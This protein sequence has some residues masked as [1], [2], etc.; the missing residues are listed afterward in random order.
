LGARSC[1]DPRAGNSATSWLP[2][3]EHDAVF[4]LVPAGAVLT[5]DLDDLVEHP[6]RSLRVKLRRGRAFPGWVMHDR[7]LLTAA[8]VML[9]FGRRRRTGG[10]SAIR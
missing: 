10:L 4:R 2:Q 8:L 1:R 9:R 6:I 5:N 3:L 7:S